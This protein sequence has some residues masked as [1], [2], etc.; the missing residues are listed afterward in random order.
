VTKYSVNLTATASLIVQV[1]AEDR[2]AAIDAAYDNGQYLCAQCTGWGQDWSL[3][4][5]EFE[6]DESEFGVEVDE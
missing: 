3:D 5:G 6:V 1:E 2:E 4:L